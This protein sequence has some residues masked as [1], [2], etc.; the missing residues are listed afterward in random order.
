MPFKVRFIFWGLN[1]KPETITVVILGLCGVG[2]WRGVSE[3]DGDRD[4]EAG[5]RGP[6]RAGTGTGS[7]GQACGD[8][9]SLGHVARPARLQDREDSYQQQAVIDGE[10]ALLDILDTA[11]QIYF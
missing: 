3:S 8:M 5:G 9:G 11:G 7:Q 6:K 4:G 1:A 2:R 10:P